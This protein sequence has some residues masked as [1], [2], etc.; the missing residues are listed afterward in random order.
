MAPRT[1]KSRA[2]TSPATIPPN[3][4]LNLSPSQSG[5]N[6][7][8]EE[9]GEENG[10][11]NSDQYDEEEKKD[12][13]GNTSGISEGTQGTRRNGDANLDATQFGSLNNHQL[14]SQQISSQFQ[15]N[16]F[17]SSGGNNLYGHISNGDNQLA[18]NQKSLVSK[19]SSGIG[20]K[21]L[22]QMTYEL[23]SA[24]NYEDWKNALEAYS[25][26]NNSFQ[27]VFQSYEESLKWMINKYSSYRSIEDIHQAH[28]EWCGKLFGIMYQSVMKLTGNVL[29][30]ELGGLQA[31]RT[32]DVLSDPNHLLLYI[33]NR[34]EKLSSF[35][36]ANEFM[37]V[38][39]MVYDPNTNPAELREKLLTKIIR[40][41]NGNKNK[42]CEEMMM[43]IIYNTIP[44]SIQPLIRGYIPNKA[45]VTFDDVY[46]A[47][48]VMYDEKKSKQ[49]A[50]R[51]DMMEITN[52]EKRVLALLRQKKQGD[53]Q[54]LQLHCWY[55]D[56]REHRKLQ[57]PKATK[58]K[59]DG[60]NINVNPFKPKDYNQK[61]KERKLLALKRKQEETSDE[62][63]EQVKPT[64]RVRF[65]MCIINLRSLSIEEV[66]AGSINQVIDSRILNS[67]KLHLDSGAFMHI[68]GD[69]AILVNIRKLDNP[70]P[71]TGAFGQSITYV[72]EVGD[73]VLNMG[74]KFREVG[75][76][77]NAHM[78]LISESRI[79]QAGYGINKPPGSPIAQIYQE[80]IKDNKKIKTIIV[81][82]T[83]DRSTDMWVLNMTNAHETPQERFLDQSGMIRFKPKSRAVVEEEGE[84]EKE[85][86]SNPSNPSN[87]K[88]KKVIP[89]KV[90]Q[91]GGSTNAAT[92][93]TE[94]PKNKRKRK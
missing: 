6:D 11:A 70:I 33:S 8:N 86:P 38:F 59:A 32:A 80:S 5:G 74:V 87:P 14:L 54:Q 56:S 20:P 60:I 78:T 42:I 41:Q 13:D 79:Q 68:T 30:K 61:L 49:H 21:S 48:K 15:G 94:L 84:E 55:C 81:E 64:Q 77:P 27:L 31:S 3:L 9:N 2:P 63:E 92:L 66:Y 7:V 76:V 24:D 90:Q 69:R 85:E 1:R 12:D 36:R 83:K 57:C 46:N 58:D 18:H 37:K 82:F 62:E 45:V 65:N 51:K 67:R 19:G 40:F 89:K 72:K 91:K 29:L 88:T 44:S 23:R 39:S 10:N 93:S 34:Y 35:S 17:A 26:A 47:L 73:I 52:K 22:P 4:P 53:K 25:L 75:I 28:E 43:T 16:G 71:L 50:P